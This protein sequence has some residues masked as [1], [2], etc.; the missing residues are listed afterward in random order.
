MK[1]GKVGPVNTVHIAG[2]DRGHNVAGIPVPDI[3]NMMSFIF[4]SINEITIQ[5]NVITQQGIAPPY[6]DQNIF[7]KSALLSWSASH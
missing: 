6:P 3:K 5:R 7:L 4:V 2:N 1:N